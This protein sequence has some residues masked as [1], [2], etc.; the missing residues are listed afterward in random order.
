MILNMI[1]I[2]N[3]KYFKFY[4]W[5]KV[6]HYIYWYIMNY[7]N[8]KK[9]GL[10]KIKNYNNINFEKASTDELFSIAKHE[11]HRIEK[12][13]Y[14]GYLNSEKINSYNKS[15]ENVREIIEILY[16]RD[17][18]IDRKDFKWLQNITD[19]FH[20]LGNY[21]NT[22]ALPV[23]MFEKHKLI[24]FLNFAKTR[25]STRSWKE[26]DFNHAELTDIARNLI[27]CAKW[28]PCSGNRQAWFFKILISDDDK[29][30]LRGIKEE[31]CINAPLVIFLGMNRDSY[32]AIGNKEHGIYVDGGAAAM[33]MITAAHQSGLGSCWNHFCKDFVYSRPK[34]LSIFNN[35]LTKMKIPKNIEPI[36]LLAFGI[37]SFISLPPERPE[38]HSLCPDLLN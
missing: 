26:S 31:H 11:A 22:N 35:F 28:A 21:L 24:E 1:K 6:I 16:S 32:G 9:Y 8:I 25:R 29:Q 23:K 2:F 27:D 14:A 34:N 4:F 13:F 30:L 37:P 33:Q 10:N 12:A 36:S 20:S 3:K 7:S 19:S 5:L 17:V 18:R 38:A 15:N